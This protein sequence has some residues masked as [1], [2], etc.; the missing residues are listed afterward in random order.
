M[1]TTQVIQT[2][3]LHEC[4]LDELRNFQEKIN[5]A[6]R[7]KMRQD[8]PAAQLPEA[9]RLGNQRYKASV[10]RVSPGHIRSTLSQYDK[11]MLGLSLGSKNSEGARLEACIKWISEN[12][13]VCAVVVGDSVYRLTLQVMQGLEP[14]VAREEGLQKGLDFM[15]TYRPMF[16]QYA[17]NCRFQFIPLSKVEKYPNFLPCYEALKL[18][19][20]EN[21]AYRESVEEFAQI[22]LGWGDKQADTSDEDIRMAQKQLAINYLLEESALFGCLSQEGWLMFVYPGS[23]KTFQDIAEGKHPEV[24]QCLR[25]L[26]FLA[27]RL[28]KGG[29]YFFDGSSKQIQ[30]TV[31]RIDMLDAFLEV[32]PVNE[33]AF[34]ADFSEDDWERFFSYTDTKSF[35]RR[36]VLVEQGLFDQSLYILKQGQVEVLIVDRE[37][38]TKTQIAIIDQGLV[39]GEQSFVDKQPRSATVVAMTDCEVLVLSPENFK[40]LRKDEPEIACSLLFDI[41]RL[42]STRLRRQMSNY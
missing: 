14:A 41:A 38:N 3:S 8:Q 26:S 35:R 6:L 37:N 19:Y 28:N 25:K 29:L 30:R 12:F 2:Q 7:K 11:C 22:Y 31:P 20:Y 23:I 32:E 42:Q 4:S 34:L 10:A 36:E 16:E 21:L 24:P 27:L 40:Q 39:F 33:N 9:I 17:K 5:S 18:L 15:N 13:K 1:D